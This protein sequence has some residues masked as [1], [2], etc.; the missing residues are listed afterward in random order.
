MNPNTADI[1]AKLW[2]EAKTL[3][4]AGVSILHYVN[5]LT[6][7][8]FLKMLEE[9]GQ[10]DLIPAEYRWIELARLE[11][12][13]QLRHY[14]KLLLDLGDPLKV[15]NQLVLAIFTDAQTAIS[16]PVDLKMLTTNIDK[17]D[18]FSAREDG[19]GD[20]YEGLMQRVMSDTKSKAG[21]YFTPRAL[22]D[23]II[24]LMQPQPGEIIQDPAAGTG[25]FL[26]AA[27]R[28]IKDQT[29][30]LFTLS[31]AQE[32]FQRRLAFRGHEFVR[33]TR[34]LCAMN[35]LLH[36]IESLIG[37]EDS[38]S[39]QGAALGA[40]H[41]ILTNPPF[42]KMPG[43]VNRQD[44]TLTAGERV[45]PMP[46]LEHAIRMLKPGGRCAIVMPDN[47]LF[48]DGTG[49]ALRRFLMVNCN[50]HTVLR[51]PTGI[52]YAQG[53]KTNVLFF[54]RVTD[55]DFPENHKVQATKEVWFYDLRSNMPT[56]GKTNA[57]TVTHFEEF[58]RLFGPDP[59]GK[60]EREEGGD[61]SRWRKLT[62]DQITARGDN[63]DWTWLRDES[64][65]PEDEMTEPD[66][67]AAAIMGHLRAALDEIEGLAEE[68]DV[69]PMVEAAE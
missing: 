64:G 45:G 55:K 37:C 59:K 46:F 51:L 22:I 17:I 38:C 10:T 23:S 25:G 60:S 34:R 2:R 18:W 63:L 30:E 67:I 15:Q 1:V 7:L 65:D 69:A 53:V 16:K 8:L 39:P 12:G 44:F 48:G 50:L 56:F 31:E 21:Q 43:T 54:T 20:L 49:T 33:D 29:D 3:Q 40:A 6:Y 4:G 19:L 35:M 52:F 11:G 68:L 32:R 24:R 62:R 9:T 5:E 14:R 28:Y 36:G 57:L 26:I 61:A 41:L 13:D 27:D 58:E 66:E 42:N 47:I